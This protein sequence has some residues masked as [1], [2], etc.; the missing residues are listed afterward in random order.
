[1]HHHRCHTAADISANCAL[2]HTLC[3]CYLFQFTK[4]LL[5]I[6]SRNVGFYVKNQTTLLIGKKSAYSSSY[7][8]HHRCQTNK[9]ANYCM[10]AQKHCV[11]LT[12]FNSQGDQIQNFERRKEAKLLI[13]QKVPVAVA[14]CASSKPLHR[15]RYI[16]QLCAS[17]YTL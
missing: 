7:M 10:L 6:V 15:C 9:S 16:S 17:S 14:T 13:G 4:S 12:S 2:A 8:N 11:N 1:M 3:E 5:K